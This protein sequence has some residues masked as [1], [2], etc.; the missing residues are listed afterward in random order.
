[1]QNCAICLDPFQHDRKGSASDII[2]L[3]C[4][5]G[6]LFHFKCLQNWA[7]RQQNCP[8][9]RKDLIDEENVEEAVLK[10]QGRMSD[11]AEHINLEDSQKILLRQM[12]FSPANLENL[13][14]YERK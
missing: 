2:E 7:V 9:C 14:T 8:L 13:N 6:H 1:M 11:L 4:N 3:N 12:E 10:A 5:E